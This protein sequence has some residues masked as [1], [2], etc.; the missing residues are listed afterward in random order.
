MGTVRFY[1]SIL[2]FFSILPRG[3]KKAPL[4]CLFVSGSQV[5]VVRGVTQPRKE[6]W[7]STLTSKVF[8]FAGSMNPL[9]EPNTTDKMSLFLKGTHLEHSA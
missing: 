7:P 5:G 1:I 6:H 3:A 9:S 8:Y 2:T 4:V